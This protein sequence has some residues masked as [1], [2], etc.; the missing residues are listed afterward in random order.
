LQI[1]PTRQLIHK[2]SELE[3][4]LQEQHVHLFADTRKVLAHLKSKRL[5]L[6]LVTNTSL[7]T[8]Q[9]PDILSI[10]EFFDVVVF[11]YLIGILKPEP[12]IYLAA[13]EQLGVAPTA[14]LFVGDGNDRELDGAHSV[15]MRTVM[16]GKQRHELVRAEQS[17]LYDYRIEKLSE[18]LPIV[19]ILLTELPQ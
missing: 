10:R 18:L 2:L 19:D 4:K 9:V 8:T 13:C 17:T 1:E 12:G 15:G 11:S 7:A 6:G 5:K 14:C 16:V 3:I